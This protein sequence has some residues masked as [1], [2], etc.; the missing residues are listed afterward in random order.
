MKTRNKIAFLLGG[1]IV[2][3]AV[4]LS[5]TV[6]PIL[7]A[8][9]LVALPLLLCCITGVGVV[10]VCAIMWLVNQSKIKK[11]SKESDKRKSEGCC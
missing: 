10:G 6:S 4:Y 8:S 1:V 5:F 2:I 9:L 11:E 7:G 3:F